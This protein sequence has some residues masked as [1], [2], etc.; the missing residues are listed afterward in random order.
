MPREYEIKDAFRL[1]IKRDARG[2]YTISTSDFIKELHQL[3]W[4]FTASEAN[5]W[6]EAHK[7]D[8]RDISVSEGQERTFQVFNPNGGM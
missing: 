1:A 4:H 2:R 3:N 6:I 8:F 7:P 5:R